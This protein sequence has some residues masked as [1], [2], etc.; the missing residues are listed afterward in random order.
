MAKRIRL[1]CLFASVHVYRLEE[2]HKHLI[3]GLKGSFA[4]WSAILVQSIQVQM[5]DRSEPSF[6]MVYEL[7]SQVNFRF[8]VQFIYSSMTSNTSSG[9]KAGRLR[10]S[11]KH[12]MSACKVASELSF[13][14]AQISTS[15]DPA[16]IY[17]T[18]LVTS[19]MQSNTFC[20]FSWLSGAQPATLFSF[21][22]ISSVQSVAWLRSPWLC[23]SHRP[24]VR[25]QACSLVI[26]VCWPV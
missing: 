3:R 17:P 9:T 5:I 6:K 12:D 8:K 25:H 23:D 15:V 26:G 18:T 7:W 14:R 2:H 1:L 19:E 16:F 13:K 20:S 24:S 4:V 11:H 22:V 10:W 21:S